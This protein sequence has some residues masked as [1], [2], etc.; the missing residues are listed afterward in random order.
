MPRTP[1]GSTAFVVD[2]LRLV[3]C[4]ETALNSAADRSCFLSYLH[5]RAE[6]ARLLANGDDASLRNPLGLQFAFFPPSIPSLASVCAT[7]IHLTTHK[8]NIHTHILQLMR[9]NN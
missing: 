6:H 9:R 5:G 1:A 8:L 7:G 4:H 3:T 2:S